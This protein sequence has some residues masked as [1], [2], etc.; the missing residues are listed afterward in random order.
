[1]IARRDII[2]GGAALAAAGLAYQLKPRKR[3]SLL[4]KQKMAAIIP[5]AFGA[6]TAENDDNQVKPETEGKLA[7]RLYS[8]M[9]ERAYYDKNTG[10]AV[11]MLIAYGDTQSD[12]LQLHRPESCYPAV[13]FALLASHAGAL[14]LTAGAAIPGRRVVAQKAD[15]KENIFYWTRLGEYLPT[16]SGDQR[17]ARFLTAVKG[18]IPDGGLFRFSV[19]S[20]QSDEAFKTLD[21]FVREMVFAVPKSERRAL[22]A[23]ELARK[24][25]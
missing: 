14:P 15:R 12:L 20:D 19:V 11:M 22:V 13:G 23:T 18:Y 1:M 24:L 3:F 6:W 8:E 10:E 7:A 4:G 5:S 21:R 2:L 17:E 25:A 16:G 9:V